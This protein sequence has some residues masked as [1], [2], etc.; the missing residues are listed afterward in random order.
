M[1]F[2]PLIFESRQKVSAK[3]QLE[4][5]QHSKNTSLNLAPEKLQRFKWHFVKRTELNLIQE[6]S[7]S[8][9]VSFSKESS[10]IKP[11]SSIALIMVSSSIL[12]LLAQC[13]NK[14]AACIKTNWADCMCGLGCREVRLLRWSIDMCL[15]RKICLIAQ[16][17][18]TAI[19]PLCPYVPATASL[20][21]KQN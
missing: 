21:D 18:K 20:L 16:I 14:N 13:W 3:L 17:K 5:S 4:M 8:S 15:D 6:K 2:E 11:S 19:L 12:T 9:E 10:S 1:L 7:S